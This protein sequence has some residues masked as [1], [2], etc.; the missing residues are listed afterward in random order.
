MRN[1]SL[2]SNIGAIL[3]RCKKMETNLRR[4]GMPAF[5]ACLPLALLACQYALILRQKNINISRIIGRIQRW[6]STVSELSA[7]DCARTE[8]IDLDRK[9]RAD[10]EGACDSMRTLCDLCAEICDMFSAVGYESPML[11]RGRDRFD[12]TVEDACSVSQSLID[13][14]DTHDRRALAIRQQQHAIE[15]AGEASA[16]AHAVR[17]AAEA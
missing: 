16:A 13:L 12:A 5:L 3:R 4:A 9:M 11:K 2:G 1:Q 6:K 14:V 17:T 10:I 8:F 7:H 15:L